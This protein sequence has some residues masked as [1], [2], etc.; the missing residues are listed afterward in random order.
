MSIANDNQ[1]YKTADNNQKQSETMPNELQELAKHRLK[2]LQAHLAEKLMQINVKKG[3]RVWYCG[4]D[5]KFELHQNIKTSDLMRSL[6]YGN[7]CKCYKFCPTC[8]WHYSCKTAADFL[9]RLMRMQRERKAESL[10]PFRLVFLTLTV[11]NCRLNE[12]RGTLREMSKAWNKL[13]KFKRFQQAA[14]GGWFRG[15]EYL[16]D[17][18]AAGKA[19]PH[20]HVLL[21]VTSSYFNHDYIKQSEWTDMWRKALQVD[22]DPVVHVERV[23]P[24]LRKVFDSAGNMSE[25]L[26]A[27][28]SAAAHEVCK[29]SIAPAQFEKMSDQDFRILYQQTLHGRQYAMGGK[30]KDTPPDDPETLDPDEWRYLGIEIWRWGIGQYV[31]T[32]FTEARQPKKSGE[33]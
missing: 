28:S 14:V 6:T 17:E 16:G 22:Y 15:V 31:M 4:T 9:G 2:L 8:S 7:F 27:A 24:R 10:K 30:V 19:H 13:V 1:Q 33:D 18:T 20:F 23:K 29:Y 11:K 21:I 26:Q 25:R 12:L 32:Q 3:V 5:L